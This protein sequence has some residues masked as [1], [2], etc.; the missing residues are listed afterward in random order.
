MRL[1][2]N[3]SPLIICASLLLSCVATTSGQDHA[4][5][6]RDLTAS[7]PAKAS[8]GTKLPETSEN[9]QKRIAVLETQLEQMHAELERLKAY[10]IAASNSEPVLAVPTT[11]IEGAAAP[12]ERPAPQRAGI[13]VGPVHLVPYGTIY[14]NLYGNSGGTNSADVPLFATPN[15]L[16]GVGGTAR[17]TRIGLK[18]DGPQIAGAKSSGVIESDFSGG[19]PAVGIGED[20]GVLRLR[21]AFMR[22]DW[23]DTSVEAGQDW[24]VFAPNNPVSLGAV[25]APEFAGS[26]NLFARIPQIRFQQRWLQGKLSWDGAIL[27]PRTGDYPLP[28]TTPAVLQPG[29]G[30][31]SRTP[32]FESRIAV[33][34]KDWFGSGK[35]GSIGISGHYGR[36][37]VATVP[38][39]I[40]IEVVGIAGDWNLPLGKR[41]IFAGEAFFGRNLAGF[42]GAVFQTFVPDFAYRVGNVLVPGGPR[43]P[44]TR[45]GW[46]QVGYTP[47]TLDGR[48]TF[49][50]GAAI[51][52]PKDE[53]FTSISRRDSRIQNRAF[54]FSFIHKYTPQLS[55]GLEYR[56]LETLYIFSGRQNNNHLN[57]SA[58]FSF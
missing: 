24:T 6:G 27:G 5:D 13:D 58:A 41:V 51:D 22:L 52:D 20:F 48:L 34:N 37:R 4:V 11:N 21:L 36:A 50:A 2:F 8:N 18:I 44:G 35:A 49:Y 28:G 32:A 23:K 17:E 47:P 43:S 46:S 26:G 19:L 9:L 7:E 1:L 10:A 45:G 12:Q 16:S 39:R 15:G 29:T 54:E 14:L 56:R 42:Q 53:D 57:L 3:L 40:D 31:A 55:W 33:N 38:K 25:G 30:S